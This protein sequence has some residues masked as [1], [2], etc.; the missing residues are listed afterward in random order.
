MHFELPAVLLP[1]NA[2]TGSVQKRRMSIQ[3]ILARGMNQ[4]SIR[5]SWD[6][7][8]RLPVVGASLHGIARR[9]L[10]LDQRVW[11]RMRVQ[12]FPRASFWMNVDPRYE[13]GH[14]LGTHEPAVQKFLVAHLRPGDRFY[15]VGA[16]IGYFSML[17]ALLV[18]E[19]GTVVALEP[20]RRNAAMLREHIA[21]N[22]LGSAIEVVE[23][24]VWS[25]PGT[26][27]LQS[28][29]T[30]PHSNT[31][32]SKV[33]SGD[34]AGAYEVPCTTLDQLCAT[35]PAPTF[36]KMDVEGAESAILEGAPQLFDSARPVLLCEIHDA[37]NSA[38]VQSWLA[39]RRYQL[40]WL[41][42]AEDFPRHLAATPPD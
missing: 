38:A 34:T 20:D 41:E 6:A 11:V 7:I 28:A 33:V 10:P 2:A 5:K 40:R 37:A 32:M 17:A 22:S 29:Q 25:R 9:L 14:Y 13:S 12:E 42:P 36:I 39:Q 1:S 21:R 35:R 27:R 18:E 19:K 30:G 23:Q 24:A 3:T 8:T 15:D 26:V 4:P 16:H 31:G